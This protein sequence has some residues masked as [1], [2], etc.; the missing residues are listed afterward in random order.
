MRR[1]VEQC[2]EIWD[3]VGEFVRANLPNNRK[4]ERYIDRLA[5]MSSAV[6]EAFYGDPRNFGRQVAD[7]VGNSLRSL[8][9]DDQ[10]HYDSVLSF[11]VVKKIVLDH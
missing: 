2:S 1:F 10:V 7:I 11:N 5:R 8:C 4:V 9:K 3:K 6:A